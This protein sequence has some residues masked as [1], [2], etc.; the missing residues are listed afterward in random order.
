MQSTISSKALMLEGLNLDQLTNRYINDKDTLKKFILDM[1]ETYTYL[2]DTY[3]LTSRDSVKRLKRIIRKEYDNV[4][5]GFTQ[6]CEFPKYAVASTGTVVRLATRRVMR[7]NLNKKGYPQLDVGRTMRVHR[8][9]ATTYLPNPNDLPQ[10][11]HIDGD[12][13]NNSV[14]NLEWCDN[15][16]NMQ[17]AVTN[18]LLRTAANKASSTGSLNNQSKL[19]EED[20]LAIR[21]YTGTQASIAARYG[22][23]RS[24]VSHILNRKTW[25]HI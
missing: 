12:K 21:T 3:H 2:M 10:V 7:Y 14:S 9:I 23:S 11:N 5:K 4:P 8:L 24:T 18:N 13:T 19:T 15:T 1:N 6:L 20:V 17:H 25:T 16:H 22:V